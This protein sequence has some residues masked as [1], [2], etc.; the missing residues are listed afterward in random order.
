MS[1]TLSVVRVTG[2]LDRHSVVA[3]LEQARFA[4]AQGARELDLQAV[5]SVD[6]CALT[7]WLALQRDA[8]AAGYQLH[9]HHLP[10]QMLSIAKLVG[11][12]ALM[13]PL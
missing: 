4:I 6:S 5:S 10:E 3:Q 2:G 13:A 8:T 11:I 12:D 7:F 9:W 1:V